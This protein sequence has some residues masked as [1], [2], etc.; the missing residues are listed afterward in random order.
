MHLTGLARHAASECVGA[1]ASSKGLH[2]VCCG[3]MGHVKGAGFVG[4]AGFCL[5]L[6][7]AFTLGACGR[8]HT[9]L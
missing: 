2:H 4:Y 1:G 8:V 3:L 7:G 9:H 5:A 6:H